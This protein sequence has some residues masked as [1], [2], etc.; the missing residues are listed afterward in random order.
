V[1]ASTDLWSLEDLLENKEAQLQYVWFFPID[2]WP[3]V[4]EKVLSSYAT[5]TKKQGNLLRQLRSVPDS[6][7][8]SLRKDIVTA[9]LGYLIDDEKEKR[10]RVNP[11]DRAIVLRAVRA[12]ETLRKSHLALTHEKSPP[13]QRVFAGP[14]LTRPRE[15]QCWKCG[16]SESERCSRASGLLEQYSHWLQK[17]ATPFAPLVGA[18]RKNALPTFARELFQFG[19]KHSGRRHWMFLTPRIQ[20]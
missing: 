5:I 18:P 9:Y 6:L 12:A 19:T 11:H 16:E 15:C 8:P 10:R 20:I 3:D 14:M 17:M 7:F 2:R 13:W 4:R 1:D